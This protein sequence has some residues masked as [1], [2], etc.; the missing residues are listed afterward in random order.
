MRFIF[1]GS[2]IPYF[3]IGF[4]LMT[5]THGSMSLVVIAALGLALA[6]LHLSFVRRDAPAANRAGPPSRGRAP[7]ATRPPLGSPA[8]GPPSA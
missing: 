5:A 7:G 3:F 8:P 6:Y 2:A 1:R 4:I